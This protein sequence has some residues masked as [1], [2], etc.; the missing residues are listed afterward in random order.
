MAAKIAN[1]NE[2]WRMKNEEWRMK[3]EEWRIKWRNKE[4]K[5]G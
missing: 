5:S 4:R 2:E 3:N 1:K